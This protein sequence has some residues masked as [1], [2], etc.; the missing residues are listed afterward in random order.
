MSIMQPPDWSKPFEIMCNASDYVVGEVLGQRIDKKLHAIYYVS[1][2]LDQAQINY[3]M[4]EK[5]L[6]AVVF[7]LDKFRS[8]LVVAKIII[9][10]DHTA[11]RYLLNKKDSKPRLLRWI[12]LL[13]E[14][15]LEIKEKKGTDN[16]V[17][18]HLSRLENMKIEQQPINDDFPYDRL[19]SQFEGNTTECSL[20]YNDIETD[21]VVEAMFTKTIVSWYADFVNYLAARV[22]PP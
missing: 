7:T 20:I 3:A 10:T 15:D 6:I 14:F 21:E 13:Q 11:I 2:T 19:V 12:L 5:E 16:I 1:R 4:I 17:A 9:Y 18:D 22:L 8:Y